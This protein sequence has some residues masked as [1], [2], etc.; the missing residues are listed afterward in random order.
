M[1]EP[2]VHSW[3]RGCC[4][5]LKDHGRVLGDGT[6]T[7]RAWAAALHAT[8]PSRTVSGKE[9][10]KGWFPL[11]VYVLSRRNDVGGATLLGVLGEAADLC[12]KIFA[13]TAM[14]GSGKS[15]R[16]RI[17]AQWL[18]SREELSEA[19]SAQCGGSCHA[20]ACQASPERAFVD[21]ARCRESKTR[22]PTVSRAER[23]SR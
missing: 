18:A 2:S 22:R 12:A 21:S 8:N 23:S 16:G 19:R 15:Q 10:R 17:P 13:T 7:G 11:V 6:L 1:R 14:S 3:K 20:Q 4:A 9:K 5:S